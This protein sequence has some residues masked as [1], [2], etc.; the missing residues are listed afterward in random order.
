LRFPRD[1]MKVIRTVPDIIPFSS[2]PASV[3]FLLSPDNFAEAWRS[4]FLFVLRA[5]GYQV[6]AR[7]Y[8]ASP[9]LISLQ[10][11]HW[12]LPGGNVKPTLFRLLIQSLAEKAKSE[13]VDLTDLSRD[14]VAK[15]QYV[16]D[17][18]VEV[19]LRRTAQFH[20]LKKDLN[21]SDIPGS[22]APG[23]LKIQGRTVRLFT[24]MKT[25]SLI[26]LF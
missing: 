4:W 2:Y 5:R 17:P 9:S 8:L 6:R 14:P 26:P 19:V 12:E 3:F 25:Y 18:R 23:L 7:P 22:E 15:F 16:T 13:C 20:H 11:S 24:H 21:P 10:T 1:V